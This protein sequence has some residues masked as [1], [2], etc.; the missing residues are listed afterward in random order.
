M[1]KNKWTRINQNQNPTSRIMSNQAQNKAKYIMVGGFLGAGKSTSLLRLATSLMAQGK[2]VGL[3]TNDQSVGLADTTLLRSHNLDVEEIPGG[4]FCCRFNSLV[5][6][7]ERLS[8]QTRP[9]I[10][11]AEPVGSC[12]DLVASVSYPLRRIYG[13]QFSIAPLS[14]L[15]DPIRALRVLGVEK[16]KSFSHKV[17][18]IYKKQLEEAQIIV[19]NKSD[20]LEPDRL[21]ALRTGLIAAFGDKPI[22]AVSA[23]QGDGL[24]EWFDLIVDSEMDLTA[25]MDLDYQTYGEGEALLGWLNATFDFKASRLIDGEVAMMDL[26]DEIQQRLLD[27]GHQIAHLKMTL[28]RRGGGEDVAALNLVDSAYVAEL[29][30]SLFDKL[31]EGE[32]I[33]NLRAEADPQALKDTVLAAVERLKETHPDLS[34]PLEHLEQF[35]PGMPKPTHRMALSDMVNSGGES[36]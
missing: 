10:F 35:R 12:T 23:R 2:T 22:V 4:C 33:V 29:S 21:T 13:D 24:D 9:D 36:L 3:I 25:T 14:V 18:Y 11:L 30:Q 31:R 28:A 34:L 15:V 26:A 32:L 6:A 20:L 17:E 7:A 27:Q 16:G 8:E 5:E 1:M 19:I